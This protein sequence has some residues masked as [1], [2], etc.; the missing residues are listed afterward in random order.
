L[1]D[2]LLARL[3]DKGGR[4]L[5]VAC[6]LGASTRR[7]LASYPPEAV[8]AINISAA[9]VA[10]ARQNAPGATVLQMDAAKLAFPD[11]SFD[12]VICVE[13][14]FHFDT[15]AAFLAEALRVL[16]PG[17]AL[18]LSDILFRGFQ[19]VRVEDRTD[20]CLGGFRRSLVAWPA[21]ERGKG[22]MSLKSSLGTAL[23]CRLIAGY[24]GA[25]SKAYLLV[26]ARK[27]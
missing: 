1:V 6:G 15:R 3:P 10:T 9:Q 2:T 26:S 23:V 12:A 27:P 17:G 5:D 8:T 25:V 13:A 11:A 20:D 22:A 7:L 21:S 14:A 16:K 24:F 4:I 18:V 19:D